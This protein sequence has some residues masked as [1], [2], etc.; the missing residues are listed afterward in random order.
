MGRLFF[1][2]AAVTE[3]NKPSTE[4]KETQNTNIQENVETKAVS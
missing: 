1:T 3:W 4:I 2:Y